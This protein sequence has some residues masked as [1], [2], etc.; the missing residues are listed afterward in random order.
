MA[1][2]IIADPSKLYELDD[3]LKKTP[4]QIDDIIADYSEMIS[5][6]RDRVSNTLNQ[7]KRRQQQAY[8]QLLD[9]QEALDRAEMSA[10]DS[11]DGH[12]SSYYYEAVES[13][14]NRYNEISDACTS[15]EQIDNQVEY[16]ATSFTRTMGNLRQDYTTLLQKSSY[17][18]TRYADLVKKSASI[19]SSGSLSSTD[20]IVQ[21]NSHSSNQTSLS[22]AQA[23]ASYMYK[24]NYGKEDYA[25]Y[26][27]NP[28]WQELHQKA[29]P[30][31][32]HSTTN[33]VNTSKQKEHR[34][35][36]VDRDNQISSIIS[37]LKQGSNKSI[38]HHEAEAILDSIHDYSGSYYS[39]I[40]D[41]YDNPNAPP[42]LVQSMN[43]IDNYIRG[44][45][46]WEGTTYRG[47]NVS[48]GTA[49]KILSS[50]TIDML[51]PASWS[52]S[53]SIAQRFSY[54]DESIQMV[55]VLDNNISGVSI[56][57]IATYNGSEK[58][59]LSP[60]GVQYIADN[61]QKCNIDGQ[62]Y[63]YVYVHEQV[64]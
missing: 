24:N 28:V 59:V 15:I 19:T 34:P 17:I 48:K 38:S 14:Q 60:S 53:E 22:P 46:K 9:A 23:L 51:G 62:S 44:A 54:G 20:K 47:I 42:R 27:Q 10:R 29:Y 40:R 4:S 30:E 49:K 43:R 52:S 50:P 57:H 39:E 13:C 25:I 11:E 56:T 55:F 6:T 5:H 32:Y 21:G 16:S 61:F 58:E 26:S 37:D 12:V 2:Q 7:W 41:A 36:I 3:N 1:G 18:L 35:L 33:S 45:V 63:I 31:L 64:K 8:E